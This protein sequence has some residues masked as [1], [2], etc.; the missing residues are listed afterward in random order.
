MIKFIELKTGIKV[1]VLLGILALV[2]AAITAAVFLTNQ[3]A[4]QRSHLTEAIEGGE[5]TLTAISRSHESITNFVGDNEGLA[6]ELLKAS[7]ASQEHA[8]ARLTS[9]RGTSD[10][11]VFKMTENY[12]FL[13][14]SS[15]IM[16]QGVDN[17]LDI[18][19]DLEKTLN[20]YRQEAYGEAAEKASVCLQTLVPL[21]G[22]FERGNQT[23]D[24]I[25]LFYVASGHKDRVKLAI[26]QY[27]NEMGIYLQYISLLE[28]IMEGY[29]YLEQTDTMNELF[30]Q[31]QHEIASEDY[32]T[33][34]RI[35]QEIF[36]QLQL[37]KD[38]QYQN[39][40][41]KIL[42]LNPNLLD[43]TAYEV[44]L[45]LKNQVKDSEG[46]EN[47]LKS[48]QKYI[49]ALSYFDQGNLDAANEAIAQGLLLLG[50]GANPAYPE[51]QRF[52]AGLEGAF[53][54]LEIRIR[55]QPDQG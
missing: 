32:E 31:L 30:D 37:L 9:A 12:E 34:Q 51:L 22:H 8:R 6:S 48:L 15:R 4:E 41:S 19:G 49:E 5:S 36:Q 27:R 29:N 54:S 38:P 10:D 18:S 52:F 26:I 50:N 17:L 14:D 45:D 20:Y 24:G 13:L 21:V 23:L 33:A 42:E 47:Y 25:N 28:S 35:L 46:F 53:S 16:T 55:G 44:A 40:T 11:F 3:G 1:A 39:A 2:M 7:K 43:G